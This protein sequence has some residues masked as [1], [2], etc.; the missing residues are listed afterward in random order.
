M[1]ARH[2]TF[3]DRIL[4]EI[5]AALRITTEKAR[6]NT[7]NPAESEGRDELSESDKSAAASLMRV[8]HAGEIAAQA[9]YRGQALVARDPELREMLLEA[10][11]E[12]HDHLAWC[13]Q[14]LSE[15]DS[16]R[17]V[18]SAL[19]YGGSFSLGIIAGLAGDRISLGFLAETEDQVTEHLNSHLDKLPAEDRRSRKI[20]TQ[21]RDDE[22]RHSEE[23]VQRGGEPLPKPVTQAM[24]AT[25][26]IMTT[27][28]AKL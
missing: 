23:A 22:L 25:A 9:F 13:E 26:K 3:G 15:L 21:M 7:P 6:P 24:T 8:N 19:W 27:L 12:E 16:Q 18:L 17:S 14:R 4:G 20:V 28:A 10:A 1:T 2:L 5:N 11:G